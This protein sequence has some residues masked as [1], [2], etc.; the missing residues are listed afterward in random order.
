MYIDRNL[1]F[2]EGQALT[3]TALSTLRPPLQDKR[4]VGKS[5]MFLVLLVTTT[6]V[7]AGATTLDIDMVT[8]DLT[9][10]ASPIALQKLVPTPIPKASLV[11]GFKLVVPMAPGA[12]EQFVALNYTVATGPFTAGNLTA[13][14]TDQPEDWR[15][16]NDPI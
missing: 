7:S 8:D 12:Y 10:M 4:D 11:Q 6:F 5:P 13:F 14:I 2:S 3:A 15:S 1:L 9:G 16:Y